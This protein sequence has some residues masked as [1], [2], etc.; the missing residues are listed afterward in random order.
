M[1]TPLL[2]NSSALRIPLADESVD[3]THPPY[4]AIVLV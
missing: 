2:A 1:T 3:L 4:C